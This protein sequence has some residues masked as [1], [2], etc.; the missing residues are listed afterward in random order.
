MS[1]I[2]RLLARA[3]A[4]LR[5]RDFEAR[6]DSEMRFHL[7]MQAQAHADAG[8]SADEARRTAALSFGGVE[9]VKE[10]CRDQRRLGVLDDLMQ[11]LRYGAR[12]LRRSPGFAAAAVLTLALG[13]GACTA[14]FS[15][16]DGVLLR[17]LPLPEPDRVVV[18]KETLHGRSQD[19]RVSSGKFHDW[20]KQA[21][22]FQ[23]IA[24][25]TGGGHTMSGVAEPVRLTGLRIS[26]DALAT[27]GM[28][29]LLG[30]DFLPAEVPAVRDFE[31]FALL[32]Y[33]L[34][35]RQFAGRPDVVGQTV[36]LSG[37]PVTIVGVLP[38]DTG[39]LG[40]GEIF[41]PLAFSEFDRRYYDTH[42]L[43]VFGRLKPGVTVAQAQAE[44]SAIAKRAEQEHP[45]SQGWGVRLVPLPETVVAEVRPV[46]FSLLGAVACLLLIACANVANLLLGRAMARSKE[47][48]VRTALGAGRARIMRQ[49]LVESALL[50]VLGG[51]LGLLLAR[52]GLAA[53]LALAPDTLPRAQHIALDGRA[54]GLTLVLA[55]LTGVAFGVAPALRAAR[56]RLHDSL[57]RAG[58][59]PRQGGHRQRL[60]SALVA[61]EVAIALVLLA[62]AGLLMRSFSRLVEVNPGFNPREALSASVF[63]QLSLRSPDA[64]AR[65][66]A[67]ADAAVAGMAAL[68]GVRAASVVT[69]LPFEAG[70]TMPFT[71]AGRSPPAGADRPVSTHFNVGP[72]YFRAMGI[73]LLRGRAFAAADVAGAP[74]VAIINE[75]IARSFF[76]GDDPVGKRISIGGPPCE[77]VGVAGDVRSDRLD[78][79]ATFQTYQPF[80]QAAPVR[81]MAFVIR[82]AGAPAA[83]IGAVRGL[84][85]RLDPNLPTQKVRPLDTLVAG[86]I[87]RQRFAMTLF[88]VFSGVALL[89]AAIG[90]Y[91]VMAYAVAQ[92]TGEIGIRMALGAHTGN[93]LR[94]VFTQGGRLVAL[95]VLA[96]VAGALLL[97]RLLEKLL[98]G[99]SSHDPLTF[100]TTV[101]LVVAVA[102]VACLVPAR[103]ATKVS[104]MVALRT[105]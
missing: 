84:L 58:R 46:L 32:G 13:I 35:Q 3:R 17:P 37:R 97:T 42:W 33:G 100:V 61:G 28:K 53:L 2:P 83:H 16:V 20:Q 105:D 49:V 102:G 27:L 15:V 75:A 4:R 59:G 101:L 43:Q 5:R 12:M 14:I 57:E 67:F 90:I 62:G 39:G 34:W 47:M 104:P 63:L 86:S 60:R 56:A 66:V 45:A 64:R 69:R 68:P 40:D 41:T 44:M 96:G 30:R 11:D 70:Q 72:A 8:M 65:S 1:T 77:I 85:S 48:A 88:T 99:V 31:T 78:G 52:G 38:R 87:A 76:A 73:P 82:T 79:E 103:R 71:V 51:T 23:S 21:Q 22:S 26:I 50:A 55:L 74:M 10:I 92:R 9:Q 93:V 54:L 18:F 89:L 7:E 95:G 25:V 94:L 98:F 6:M 29:P 36:Q 81:G 19:F 24:A 80:A 91:G